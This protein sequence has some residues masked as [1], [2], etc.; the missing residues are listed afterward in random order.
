MQRNQIYI[1]SQTNNVTLL[2]IILYSQ[3]YHQQII[4]FD[5]TLQK[6]AKHETK[7]KNL[8]S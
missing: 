6:V 2:T 5:K 8:R 4:D 3:N 7:K 1:T